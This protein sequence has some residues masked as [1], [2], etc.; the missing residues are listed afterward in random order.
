MIAIGDTDNNS[1]ITSAQKN[2]YI[3]LLIT[4]IFSSASDLLLNLE[5]S[6]NGTSLF[7]RRELRKKYR[8]FVIIFVCIIGVVTVV[9]GIYGLFIISDLSKYSADDPKSLPSDLYSKARQKWEHISGFS[10]PC[11]QSISDILTIIN[12]FVIYLLVKQ[13]MSPSPKQNSDSTSL[14]EMTQTITVPLS[15]VSKPLSR[16]DIAEGKDSLSVKSLDE[17]PK[18]KE[19][20]GD[21]RFHGERTDLISDGPTAANSSNRDESPPPSATNGAI[22]SVQLEGYQ[23][24]EL[25]DI[26]SITMDTAL[27]DDEERIRTQLEMEDV[28]GSSH[29]ASISNDSTASVIRKRKITVLTRLFVVALFSAFSQVFILIVSGITDTSSV[30]RWIVTI[31]LGITAKGVSAIAFVNLSKRA[32]KGV[33]I[34]KIRRGK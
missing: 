6:R 4:Y 31:T 24:D 28:V 11:V 13:H 23:A 21:E 9:T 14:M 12:V 17:Q 1:S 3:L 10:M 15:H 2:S 32:M 8:I 33:K 29:Q 27:Q 25:N 26:I 34:P 18:T 22:V 20:Y 7:S 19:I 5:L 30:F 16:V